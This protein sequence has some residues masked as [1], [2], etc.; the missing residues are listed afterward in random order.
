[1]R[2]GDKKNNEKGRSTRLNIVDQS[3]ADTLERLRE[4]PPSPR[5]REIRVKAEG[6]QR[7]VAA[8]S[9]KP[10]SE[11]QRN[12]LLKLALLDPYQDTYAAPPGAMASAGI[13]SDIPARSQLAGLTG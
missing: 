10:P 1:M 11:M 13:T 4:M 3:L 12:E 8:W 9:A 6:F 2:G 7:V 5:V